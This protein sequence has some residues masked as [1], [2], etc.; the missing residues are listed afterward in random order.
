MEEIE[1]L[2]ED[3]EDHPSNDELMELSQTLNAVGQQRTPPRVYENLDDYV[4]TSD[5][6]LLRMQ[7]YADQNSSSSNDADYEE[8]MSDTYFT[9]SEDTSGGEKLDFDLP[10]DDSDGEH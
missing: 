7:R 10:G 6:T 8:E 4:F 5:S 3:A 1:E 2:M 9:G